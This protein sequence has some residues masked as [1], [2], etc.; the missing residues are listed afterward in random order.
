M[1]ESTHGGTREG[2]GRPEGERK[3]QITIQ[4]PP[5]LVAWLDTLPGSRSEVIEEA[6]TTMRGRAGEEAPEGSVAEAVIRFFGSLNGMD[7]AD[8]ENGSTVISL[9]SGLRMRADPAFPDAEFLQINSGGGWTQA[10]THKLAEVVLL[11]HAE[12]LAATEGGKV[13]RIYAHIS[14]HFTRKT[15][16]MA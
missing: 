8:G 6:L 1:T 12:I 5:A 9:R 16:F 14:D 11:Q 15:G 13:A 3:Q 7:F 4:L 10:Y 2:A